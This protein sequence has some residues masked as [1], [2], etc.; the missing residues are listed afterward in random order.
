MKIHIINGPNL[1]ML[2]K[3]EES[4][5]G[6]S[7]LAT[8]EESLKIQFPGIS[9]SFF[10]SNLEGELVNYVQNHGDDWMVINAGAYTH[11][12]IALRDALLSVRAKFLEVHISNVY[13]RESFR[14]QSFLSD[15]ASGVLA[16]LGPSVYEIAVHYIYEKHR[17]AHG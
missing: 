17:N 13:A 9:F 6:N 7:T 4:I 3:R 16:G 8:I 15:I 2:G 14:H 1:N 12:S 11:T 5:Y 10:Q